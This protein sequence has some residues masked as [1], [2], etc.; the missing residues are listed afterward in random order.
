MILSENRRSDDDFSAASTN[1]NQ[2][3]S[4]DATH[5]SGD[6][7]S[8]VSHPQVSDPAE[9]TPINVDDPSHSATLR[10]A[11]YR[12]SDSFRQ[13]TG[14]YQGNRS[15]PTTR[16]QTTSTIPVDEHGT[17]M[18]TRG[19]PFITLDTQAWQDEYG[20]RLGFMFTQLDQS[21]P[22]SSTTQLHG[23]P[24]YTMNKGLKLFGNR[25]IQAI[26]SEINNSMI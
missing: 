4:T 2:S 19:N 5:R 17:M 10:S 8:I 1:S 7:V 21:P 18:V 14:I 16:S 22:D 25:G 23:T 26:R 11:L 20:E 24:Q 9:P 6:D 3:G 12:L 15:G 13:V